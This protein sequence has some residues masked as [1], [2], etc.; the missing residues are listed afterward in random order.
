MR[1]L[2][3]LQRFFLWLHVLVLMKPCCQLIIVKPFFLKFCLCR[4]CIKVLSDDKKLWEDEVYKFARKHQLEVNIL[5]FS[6][7][8]WEIQNLFELSMILFIFS[9][10]LSPLIFLPKQWSWTQQFMKWFCMTSSRKMSRYSSNYIKF[11]LFLLIL[12]F[13]L[14][15]QGPTGTPAELWINEHMRLVW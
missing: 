14:S 15:N 10:R 5:S 11:L 8:Y 6:I 7:F 13:W 1:Q 3:G 2:P 12:W 9:I 4:L